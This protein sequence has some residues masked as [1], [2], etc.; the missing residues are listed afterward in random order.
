MIIVNVKPYRRRFSRRQQWQYLITAPN[1]EPIS[2]K[3]DTVPTYSAE[4]VGHDTAR[5][6]ADQ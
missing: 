4:E 3:A 6:P 5:D 1:G 2:E